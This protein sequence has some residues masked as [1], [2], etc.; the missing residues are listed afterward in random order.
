MTDAIALELLRQI[1]ENLK[2][3]FLHS[4]YDR[5]VDVRKRLLPALRSRLEREDE[6][7]IIKE[8]V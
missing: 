7:P 8:D 4:N 2:N 3:W 6:K 5:V 1:E